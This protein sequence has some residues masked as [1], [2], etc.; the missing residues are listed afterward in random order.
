MACN[1]AFAEYAHKTQEE[2]VGLTDYDIFDA[3]TA[4]HF[5][6]D[7]ERFI[8]AFDKDNMLNT[9]KKHGTFIIQ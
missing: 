2:I 8:K 6:E 3:E 1:Q 7:R 4:A 9:I 5:V